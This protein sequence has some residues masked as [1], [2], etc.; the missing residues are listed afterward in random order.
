[1]DNAVDEYLWSLRFERN[2]SNNTVE[3]YGRDLR[4]LLETLTDD[5]KRDAPKPKDIKESDLVRHLNLLRE[6]GKSPRSIARATSAIR[7]FFKE[8]LRKEVLSASPAELLTVPKLGRSLP[9]VLTPSEVELLLESPP[10]DTVLGV[11]DR[12]MLATLYATG[13]RVSELITLRPVDL[14]LTKGFL[15]ATGKGQKQ[16]LIPV[17]GHATDRIQTYLEF[18]RP[19]LAAGRAANTRPTSPLFLTRRGGGM[20]RQGFWK[21]LRLLAKKV[22]IKKPISPHKLR[23]S[24]ASHLLANGADLRAIQAMLGHADI[25]TTQ[26][27][28]HVERKAL[29]KTYEEHHPRA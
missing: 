25:S 23:H 22:G 19:Q 21:R 17:G 26:I 20:T 6:D 24:F 7:S 27:Y 1:M 8:L 2:L 10:A 13:V 28:T 4:H 12:A 16:R 18:S 15:M 29:K 5:G 14:D 3:S 9:E 11:R